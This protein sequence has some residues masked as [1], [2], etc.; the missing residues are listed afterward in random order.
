MKWGDTGEY[1]KSP[2]F[3]CV[4]PENF[5]KKVGKKAPIRVQKARKRF[6]LWISMVKGAPRGLP[7]SAVCER[8]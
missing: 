1:R 2:H 7:G 4:K 6:T 5:F 8:S 3:S